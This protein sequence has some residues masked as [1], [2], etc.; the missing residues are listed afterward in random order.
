[1]ANVGCGRELADLQKA[2]AVSQ[3]AAEAAAVTAEKS[4]QEE[5]KIMLDQQKAASQK[6][7][8]TLIMQ[9]C[10]VNHGPWAGN[11]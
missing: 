5:V 7:K 2:S 8:E 4:K 3:S 10:H 6:D 1:M 11:L 9:V